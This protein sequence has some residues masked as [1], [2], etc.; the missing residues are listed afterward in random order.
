MGAGPITGKYPLG[1]IGTRL[2]AILTSNA[3]VTGKKTQFQCPRSSV[4]GGQRC[5]TRS[6]VQGT[7][8]RSVPGIVHR[9]TV[10]TANGTYQRDVR[11]NMFVKRKPV[12]TIG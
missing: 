5:S 3:E 6:M 9:V 10:R 2:L 7:G 1:K 8:R 11:K 12:G 4:G